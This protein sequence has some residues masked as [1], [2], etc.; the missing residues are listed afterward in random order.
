MAP[1]KK[2]TPQPAP[3]PG[4]KT[5]KPGP[6]QLPVPSRKPK[7]PMTGGGKLFPGDF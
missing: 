2:G 4:K 1:A 5:K 6:Q 3:A 7:R